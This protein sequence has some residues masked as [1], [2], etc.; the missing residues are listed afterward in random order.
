VKLAEA[1]DDTASFRRFCG[2]ACSEATP[3]RPNIVRYRATLNANGLDRALFEAVTAQL[4]AR[5]IKVK[6]GTLVIAKIIASASEGDG[7]WVKHKGK[8]AVH[9][10]KAHVGGDA[11]TAL[12]ERVSI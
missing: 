9:G 8:P 11:T 2:F 1:P 4:M 5:A 12:V 10:F 6:T 7:R 3:E